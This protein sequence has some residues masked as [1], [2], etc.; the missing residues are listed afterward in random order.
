[1]GEIPKGEIIEIEQQYF[2]ELVEKFEQENK[3]KK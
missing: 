2:K 3:G 1:M